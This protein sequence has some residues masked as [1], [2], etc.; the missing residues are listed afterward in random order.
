MQVR[1]GKTVRA[2]PRLSVVRKR[3]SPQCREMPAFFDVA[4]EDLCVHHTEYD[5]IVVDVSLRC[6]QCSVKWRCTCGVPCAWCH[7]SEQ[8]LKKKNRETEVVSKR[9][10]VRATSEK[11]LSGDDEKLSSESV[12]LLDRECKIVRRN[13]TVVCVSRVLYALLESLEK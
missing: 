2:L 5:V 13:D 9:V 11:S 8:R 6:A 1:S 4:R 12:L 3:S 7:E 10:P